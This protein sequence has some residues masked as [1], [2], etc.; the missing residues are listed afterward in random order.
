MLCA[1]DVDVVVDE[2]ERFLE[3]PTAR[4]S[5]PRV[6]DGTLT[7]RELEVAA[8]VGKGRTNAQI[9]AQLVI[10]ERTV[11]S[12]VSAVLRKLQMSSRSMIAAWVTRRT[13]P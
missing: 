11:E 3:V 9:A 13:D 6:L 4:S 2:I 1:G 7:P 12:H 8:L 5:R 10:S